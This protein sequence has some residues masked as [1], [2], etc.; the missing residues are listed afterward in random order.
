MMFELDNVELKTDREF[1]IAEIAHA[2]GFQQGVVQAM[3]HVIKRRL[4]ALQ[5]NP[6][7]VSASASA[8]TNV[9]AS[10]PVKQEG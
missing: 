10:A 6:T 2:Q 1:L 4:I 5:T 9:S 7:N 3:Q 8:G